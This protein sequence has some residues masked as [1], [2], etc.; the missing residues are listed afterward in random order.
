MV[1]FAWKMFFKTSMVRWKPSG[2]VFLV[3]VVFP[4]CVRSEYQS[5]WLS[6][7][8]GNEARTVSDPARNVDPSSEKL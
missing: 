2:L 3:F 4:V 6:V 7:K 5:T 8:E 1:P